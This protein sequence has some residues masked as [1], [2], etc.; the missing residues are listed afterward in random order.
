MTSLPRLIDSSGNEVRRIRPAHLSIRENIVPLS[1]AEMELAPGDSVPY[2]SYM[3][4]FTV[5]G[6]AGYYRAKMPEIGYGS[7]SNNVSLEHAICEIGD[8]IVKGKIEQTTK[9]LSQAITQIFSHYS[10][11]KWQLGTVSV[12]ADVTL[13]AD[14]SNILQ[15]INSLI[16]Q[17]PNAVMTFD[18][19]T[20]P[21][22]FNVVARETTVTAEG[23]LGRNMP[24]VQIGRN[25]SNLCTR[26]W[27]KNLNAEASLSYMDADTISTYGVIEKVLSDNNYTTLVAQEV[28]SRYLAKNKRPIY[29]VK[30][31]GVDLSSVTGETLDRFRIGKLFR[32]VIPGEVTPIEETIVGLS[33]DD[34]FNTPKSV[35]ITLSEENETGTGVIQKLNS[36]VC[37]TNAVDGIH[38]TYMSQT[39]R[40]IQMV[41]ESVEDL[42]DYTDTELAKKY[43]IRSGID[44]KAEGIE[45]SGGKYIKIKAGTQGVAEGVLDVDTSNF[46]LDSVNKTIDIKTNNFTIDSA[47]QKFLAGPWTYDKYGMV[48]DKQP[49]ED[50]NCRRRIGI[51]DYRASLG[52]GENIPKCNWVAY[53]YPDSS[54]N[55]PY[56]MFWGMSFHCNDHGYGLTFE[57]DE[58][59]NVV[60]TASYTT[61]H[62]I[63]GGGVLG[64]STARWG[65]ITVD[66]IDA[67]SCSGSSSREIKHDIQLLKDV[68]EIIDGLRPV[69]F[70]F[71]HDKNE[72]TRIGLIYEETILVLPEICS[73]NENNKTINYID[74]IP[75]LLKEIQSLRKRVEELER[76]NG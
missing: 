4:L 48:M 37:G 51:G 66:S 45:I 25:D 6:S 70:V 49:D 63:P 74:L 15:T 60:I 21:W 62:V 24:S 72:K 59:D 75:V 8:F 14:F 50:S 47:N 52:L 12:T 69:T 55:F 1:T 73:G 56:K 64:T 42:E 28:A 40:E 29:S 65:S 53:I 33:W 16:A 10:G 68:G 26:V 71:N 17:V 13:S 35:Q 20:S 27:L 9:T 32:L 57:K 5:N 38:R 61:D 44:I 43:T 22:T 41:A 11:S 54:Q 76:K 2:R 36:E 23:R 3:E 30:I 7:V 18:F 58:T 39:D 31:D 46:K 19:S 67:Y 34:V